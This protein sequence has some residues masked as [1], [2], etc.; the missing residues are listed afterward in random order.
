MLW[1]ENKR[2]QNL[3]KHGLDFVDAA[4]LFAGDWI[5]HE[6]TRYNYGEQR[7]IALGTI[8]GRVCL[9]VYTWRQGQRRIISLR[10]G[11]SCEQAAYYQVFPKP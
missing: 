3:Q 5:E 1:D 2:Q 4:L 9:C 6:D 11:N 7:W 10:K 8:R